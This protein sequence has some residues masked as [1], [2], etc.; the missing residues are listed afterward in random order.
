MTTHEKCALNINNTKG[1]TSGAGP[2]V[3]S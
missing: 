3:F 2:T 1:A